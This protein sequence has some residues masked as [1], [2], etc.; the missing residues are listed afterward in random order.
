MKGH[1]KKIQILVTTVSRQALDLIVIGRLGGVLVERPP[2]V[3][4]V[5]GTIIG[6][7]LPN[8]LNMIV[9]AFPPWRS[10]LWG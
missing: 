5:A 7:V 10:G 8:T 9:M 6:R 4:D 1:W 3:R 2:R